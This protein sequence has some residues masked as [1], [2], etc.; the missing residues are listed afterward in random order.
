VLEQV[1]AEVL[2]T[3]CA[4]QEL[5]LAQPQLDVVTSEQQLRAYTQAFRQMMDQVHELLPRATCIHLFYAGPPSLAF[6]CGQQISKTIHPRI[7]VYNYFGM[8]VPKYSWGLDITRD[9]DA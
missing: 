9:I 6:C 8:D 3:P 4:S 5:G 7:I 2:P 1:V